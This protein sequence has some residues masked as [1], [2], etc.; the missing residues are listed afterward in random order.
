MKKGISIF[1]LS[2]LL[3]GCQS[4]TSMPQQEIV[5]DNQ[6]VEEEVEEL[7]D[8]LFNLNELGDEYLQPLTFLGRLG[9]HD[10]YLTVPYTLD[11]QAILYQTSASRLDVI[12]EVMLGM[13]VFKVKILDNQLY[14]ITEEELFIFDEELEVVQVEG[15]PDVINGEGKIFGCDFNQD[16]TMMSY[17]NTEGLWLWNK[18]SEP[19]LL[20]KPIYYD[21]QKLL[22]VSYYGMP[23]FINNG[24]HLIAEIGGY[25]AAAGYLICELASQTCEKLEVPAQA[26]M[27]DLAYNEDYLQ[28]FVYEEDDFV[29]RWFGLKEQQFL[30]GDLIEFEPVEGETREIM[31]YMQQG[32]EMVVAIGIKNEGQFFPKWIDIERYEILEDGTLEFLEQLMIIEDIKVDLIGF[33]QEGKVIYCLDHDDSGY[34][35]RQFYVTE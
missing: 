19:V 7:S 17:S 28:M 5:E 4:V 18:G 9:G 16:L 26:N 27:M 34:S 15:L 23:T 2:M 13:S 10:L 21:A 14:V 33:T 31:D 6:G 11:H 24:Q 25:E 22:E 29:M 30:E 3:A 32:N 12:K 20:A 1:I 35:Q 8:V